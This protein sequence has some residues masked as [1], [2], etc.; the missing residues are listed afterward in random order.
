MTKRQIIQTSKN[1]GWNKSQLENA[2]EGKLR[3]KYKARA[4]VIARTETGKLNSAA[5]ISQF[6][7]VGFEYYQWMTT[8]DGRERESHKTLNG[9]ICSVSNPS[10]YYTEN[11]DDPM[12]PIEHAR[13]SEMFIG[14]PGEDFQCRCSMIA[15]DPRIDGMYEIKEPEAAETEEET[16]EGNEEQIEENKR[17]KRKIEILQAANERHEKRTDMQKIQIQNNLNYRLEVRE[18][19]KNL[20]PK[21]EKIFQ[22]EVNELKSL[23]EKGNENSY[24]EIRNK[25]YK[26]SAKLSEFEKIKHIEKTAENINKYGAEK[27]IEFNQIIQ[28]NFDKWKKLPDEKA[29]KGVNNAIKKLNEANEIF[30][31]IYKKLANEIEARIQAKQKNLALQGALNKEY[32]GSVSGKDLTSQFDANNITPTDFS[33]DSLFSKILKPRFTND[34]ARMQGF[35]APAKLVSEKE[36]DELVKSCQ[37]IFYRT[38][39]STTFNGKNM[40]AKEFASQMYLANKMDLNG[41]GKRYYGDGIYTVSSTKGMSIPDLKSKN[42]AY[43]SSAAYGTPGSSTTL[44]MTWVNKPKIIDS[45]ELDKIWNKLS[46]EEKK[47][48][49]DHKNTYACALGY[50]A[51][52]CDVGNYM[53]VFNRSN[54]AVKE[55]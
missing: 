55:F 4:E 31:P 43:K 6:E 42:K 24:R 9:L 44:E 2:I 46:V 34:I 7:E 39:N 27:L 32:K 33:N 23:L 48:F 50:D 21:A 41:S 38:V 18:E 36:F 22:N 20:R 53:V 16:E 12:H 14:N 52:Y 47:K 45:A 13:T 35:D 54:I 5:K 49:G 26:I 3:G 1:Q 15:W 11:P 10:V 37:D 29:L 19:A 17:L 8:I 40:T 30:M 51:K 28:N 25:T